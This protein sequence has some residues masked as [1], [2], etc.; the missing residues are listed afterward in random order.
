[1]SIS[2]TDLIL[3]NNCVDAVYEKFNH[4]LSL[5]SIPKIEDRT[6]FLNMILLK[7]LEVD[8]KFFF[9]QKLDSRIAFPFSLRQIF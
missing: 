2:N 3:C 9:N 5:R 4:F 8:R 6:K 1:M 7:I